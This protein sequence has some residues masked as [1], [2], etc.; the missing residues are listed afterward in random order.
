MSSRYEDLAGGI[1]LSSAEL[2][3]WSDGDLSPF[4]AASSPRR[5]AEYVRPSP[6]VQHHQG[7][8]LGQG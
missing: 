7:L 6:D 8:H 1:V 3:V 5:R 2:A 4:M